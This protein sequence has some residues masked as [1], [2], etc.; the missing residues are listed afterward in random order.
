M[1][2]VLQTTFIASWLCQI[3]LVPKNVNGFGLAKPCKLNEV[4]FIDLDF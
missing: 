3:T 4:K 1:A 2:N